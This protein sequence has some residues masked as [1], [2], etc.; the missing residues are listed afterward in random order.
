[1][2]R[3]PP[4]STLFPYTTLFRSIALV[5]DALA[6]VDL[7]RERRRCVA[8]IVQEADVVGVE[9]CTG[10]RRS[11]GPEDAVRRG[12]RRAV[13]DARERVGEARPIV[14]GHPEFRRRQ[15]Y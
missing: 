11:V 3:R 10:E 9:L 6:I 2:I 12:L 1:M 14:I 15:Q 13:A 4:R 7:Y 8:A 5:I